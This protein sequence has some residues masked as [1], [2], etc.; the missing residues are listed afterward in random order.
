MSVSF[1]LELD[2]IGLTPE[3][4]K[5]SLEQFHLGR[6][7]V[8]RLDGK[9]HQLYEARTYGDEKEPIGAD[10]QR[11]FCWK[12]VN[13][14]EWFTHLN[15]NMCFTSRDK[16]PIFDWLKT[17]RQNYWCYRTYLSSD[18]PSSETFE[19]YFNIET[20]THTGISHLDLLPREGFKKRID[21]RLFYFHPFPPND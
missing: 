13:I 9:K 14:N 6:N 16:M 4:E 17:L 2:L 11:I 3:V 20:I 21:E 12:G 8:E 18:L 7:L 1:Y 10:D 19:S 5:V 15:I